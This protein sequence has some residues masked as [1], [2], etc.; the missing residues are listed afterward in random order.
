MGINRKQRTIDV[1]DLNIIRLQEQSGEKK[2]R[3]WRS[4]VFKLSL[5][6]KLTVSSRDALKKEHYTSCF[7]CLNAQCFINNKNRGSLRERLGLAQGIDRLLRS[8]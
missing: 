3:Y 1:F 8:R 5:D 7:A 6:M 4:V 2:C